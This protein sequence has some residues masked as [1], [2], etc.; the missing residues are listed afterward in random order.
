MRHPRGAAGRHHLYGAE[1]QDW[2][3]VP[4]M[5]VSIQTYGDLAYWQPHLHPLVTGGVLDRE[6][7]RSRRSPC[8]QPACPRSFSGAGC[9]RRCGRIPHDV[10]TIEDDLAP[11]LGAQSRT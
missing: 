7:G 11:A 2:H 4:G 9:S 1:L 3:T 10:E 5:V 6:G 8:H